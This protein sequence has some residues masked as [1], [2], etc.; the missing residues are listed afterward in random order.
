MGENQSGGQSGVMRVHAVLLGLLGLVL[1][2]ALVSDG[3]RTSTKVFIALFF[4][5]NL[6]VFFR[7]YAGDAAG[8]RRDPTSEHDEPGPR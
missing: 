6:V 2:L 1:L 5:V 8:S 3:T 4:V 7:Q